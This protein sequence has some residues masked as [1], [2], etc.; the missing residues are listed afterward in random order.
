MDAYLSRVFVCTSDFVANGTRL[1]NQI[2]FVAMF[3]MANY[4]A[5]NETLI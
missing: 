2:L 5:V 3:F 1:L 4:D